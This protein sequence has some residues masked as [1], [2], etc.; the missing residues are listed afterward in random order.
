[1]QYKAKGKA[2][3]LDGVLIKIRYAIDQMAE[4]ITLLTIT[5]LL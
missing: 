5:K 2:K 4:K 3:G 1:M